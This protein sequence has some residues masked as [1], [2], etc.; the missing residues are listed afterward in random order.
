MSK[1][2]T[3]AK[4]RPAKIATRSPDRTRASLIEAAKHLFAR[5]GLHGVSVAEIAAE[6]GVSTAMI[7]HHFGGKEALYRACVAGFGAARLAALERLIVIPRTREELELRL[8]QI[9]TELLEL[10]MEDLDMVAILLRDANA[11]EHWGPE[12]ERGVY[13]FSPTLAR[14]F[15]GA[16]EHGLLRADVD[17]QV[18]AALLYLTLSGLLQVDA[19]RERVTGATLRDPMY[20]RALVAK[21]IDVVLRGALA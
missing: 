10:H 4:K 12:V 8:S 14:F 5:R 13:R 16:Q 3:R 9:V 11:A 2:R 1:A 21:L 7:N 6:A 18:P 19:H 20:R 15:A 17:P